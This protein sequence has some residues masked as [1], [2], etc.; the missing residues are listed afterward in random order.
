MIEL[1]GF[2]RTHPMPGN[3]L[4]RV[5][6]FKSYKE[7]GELAERRWVDTL[8]EA[9]LVSSLVTDS[10]NRH[11]PVLDLDFPAKLIESSTPGHFHLYLNHEMSWEHYKLL[12]ETMATVGILEEGYVRASVAEDRQATFV[13]LPWIKKDSQD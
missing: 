3:E 8:E 13:R 11:R 2:E 7:A 4:A 5:D 1:R 9:N 10:D 12:L 6:N